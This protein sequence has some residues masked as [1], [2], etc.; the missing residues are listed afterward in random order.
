MINY[1][2]FPDRPVAKTSHFQPTGH[3]VDPWLGNLRSHV[4]HSM[5][6]K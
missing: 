2:D 5:A 3:K 6:K 1:R 4:L